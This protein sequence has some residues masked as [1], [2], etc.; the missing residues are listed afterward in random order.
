MT[1]DLY[2]D[3]VELGGLQ[4]AL[5]RTSQQN[6]VDLGVIDGATSA[7]SED[8]NSAKLMSDRGTIM[9]YL[10][11]EERRF[12]ISIAEVQ[13]SWAEGVTDDLLAVVG[14]A[15]SWRTGATLRELNSRFP[16][17]EYS[18]LAQAYEDG[19][20]VAIQWG[21]LLHDDAF[22]DYRSLTQEVYADERLRALFPF[23]SMGMLRLSAD[24]TSRQASEIKISPLSGGGYRV[25]STT[26]DGQTHVEHMGQVVEAAVSLLDGL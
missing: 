25:E 22:A 19:D 17:M 7:S 6:G 13:H 16:F 26:S 4:G 8:P 15:N 9:I 12:Y 20:P 5:T 23:Y 10:G 18:E 11:A 24:H 1:E 14:V 3:L 2:P 21:T